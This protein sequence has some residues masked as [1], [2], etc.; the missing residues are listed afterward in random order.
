[1]LASKPEVNVFKCVRYIINIATTNLRFSITASWKNVFLDESNNDNWK[2]PLQ[3][4]EIL[5]SNG[6]ILTINLNL[7][8]MLSNSTVRMKLFTLEIGRGVAIGC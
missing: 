4:P 7:L 5:K 6:N 3:K 2:W 8:Q 1:M